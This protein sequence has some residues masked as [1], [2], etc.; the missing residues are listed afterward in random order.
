MTVPAWLDKHTI[1]GHVLSRLTTEWLEWSYLLDTLR[2]TDGQRVTL[3][4]IKSQMPLA[5]RQG[6]PVV[7][8]SHA[9]RFR[10]HAP[11]TDYMIA[12]SEWDKGTRA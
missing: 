10:F 11:D 9:I 2:E 7:M 5:V 1:A 12:L 4:H 6:F 8:D 3:E